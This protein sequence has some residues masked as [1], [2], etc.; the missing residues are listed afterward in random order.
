[1]MMAVRLLG[2]AHNNNFNQIIDRE[3][4]PG[5]EDSRLTVVM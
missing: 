4:V 1:M 2:R 3:L 5:S